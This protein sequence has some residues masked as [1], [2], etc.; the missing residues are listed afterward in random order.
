MRKTLIGILAGAVLVFAGCGDSSTAVDS[1]RADTKAKAT[2]SAK[3]VDRDL[4]VITYD[5]EDGETALDLLEANGYDVET[6]SSD[7]GSYVTAIG[8]VEAT[9]SKYWTYEVDGKMPNLGA[10]KYE[11]KDGQQVEWKYGGS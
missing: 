11:T 10:D 5:G 1:A 3:A 2:E 8:D 9:S 7:L 4:T 6:K